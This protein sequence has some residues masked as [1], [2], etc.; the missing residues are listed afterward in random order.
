MDLNYSVC[1]ICSTIF[2]GWNTS[3]HDYWFDIA[4]FTYFLSMFLY[5]FNYSHKLKHNISLWSHPDI[6]FVSFVG[7]PSNYGWNCYIRF[8]YSL[9]QPETCSTTGIFWSSLLVLQALCITKSYFVQVKILLDS[10]TCWISYQTLAEVLL[11][12][13]CLF[14]SDLLRIKFSPS[15]LLKEIRIV[16]WL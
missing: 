1:H 7:R 2:V 3:R 5:F 9:L 16:V 10:R 11:P 12:F 15:C 8:C 14:F 6:T 13:F 4:M